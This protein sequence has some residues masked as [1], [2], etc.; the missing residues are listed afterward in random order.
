ATAT[1]RVQDDILDTLDLDHAERVVTGFNRPNL[2]FEVRSTPTANDKRRALREFLDEH[3]GAGLIYV[4]TRKHAEDVTRFVRDEVGREVRA[5]HAGLPDA[6][7]TEVQDAFMTGGL[8]LV[9][10]T[11]AFGMGVDRA[12]VRFVVH[13]GLPSTLRA[14][15]PEAG[16][17]GRDGELAH[18]LLF[19]ATQDASLRGWFI[20][21]HA[22]A[23]RDLRA[24]HRPLGR[25]A[26]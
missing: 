21:Q 6:E 13:W 11:N 12:D 9:V 3:E 5:Y 16:R 14:Y 7:R 8:D 10:A 19:Y 22:P 26:E 24:L 17:A 18:A 20:G 2:L 23:E 15:S 25:R 4:G 1:P